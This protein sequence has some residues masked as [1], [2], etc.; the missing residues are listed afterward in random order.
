MTLQ[1]EHACTHT[2][3]HTRVVDIIFGYFHIKL[4]M[5]LLHITGPETLKLVLAFEVRTALQ[6]LRLIKPNS[7]ELFHACTS[8]YRLRKQ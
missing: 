5:V 8:G 4:Q 3:M 6:I 1:N 2:R 7:Y